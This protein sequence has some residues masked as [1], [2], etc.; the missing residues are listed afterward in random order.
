MG[1]S[2]I[3]I[4]I[5]INSDKL[6]AFIKAIEG[7]HE[8]LTIVVDN[9][10]EQPFNDTVRLLEKLEDEAFIDEPKKLSKNQ[11]KEKYRKSS[12]YQ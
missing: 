5:G 11:L 3:I 8:S 9:P 7:L 2:P 4:S 10:V 6:E 1:R 12:K